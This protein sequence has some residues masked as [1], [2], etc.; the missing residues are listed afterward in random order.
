MSTLPPER[1]RSSDAAPDADASLEPRSTRPIAV[2]VAATLLTFVAGAS[3]PTPLYR[4]YQEAWGFSPAVLTLVYAVYAFA[5]L[6]ALLT[7]GTMSDRIGRRPVI[8]AALLIQAVAVS[9][10]MVADDTAVLFAARIVQGFATGAATG[11]LGAALLDV[12]PTHGALVNSLVLPLGMG[13]GA[14]GA[15]ALVDYAPWPMRLV[16]MLLMAALAIEAVLVLRMPETHASPA[17]IELADL[18]RRLRPRLSAPPQARAVLRAVT[19]V[20]V[21][22]WALGGFYL[23]LMP[24][25]LRDATGATAALTGGIAVA[26]LTVAGAAGILVLRGR[27]AGVILTVGASVLAV[28][29]A[30]VLSGVHA[31]RLWI[32]LVGTAVAGFGWGG[33]FLGVLRNLLPTAAPAE[34]AGLMSTYFVQ[35]YLAMSLPAIAAGLAVRSRGLVPTADVYGSALLALT[36][37]TLAGALLPRL[38]PAPLSAP[39][40]PPRPRPPEPPS[41]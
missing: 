41:E 14:L 35:S 27:S 5:L 15:G 4:V 32:L 2:L 38:V 18:S 16:Y 11:A 12:E 23:S 22:T 31:H 28:G 6:L 3:A 37:V 34:R 10:F 17:R 40:T 21:A 1:S 39:R 29:L 33:A 20:N 30:V 19:P 36:L 9:L 25:L 13:V 7:V 26:V 24:S 8:L